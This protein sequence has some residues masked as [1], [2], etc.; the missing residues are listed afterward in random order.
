MEGLVQ[1]GGIERPARD[2]VEY[3]LPGP[4]GDGLIDLP[5]RIVHRG[6][7][8][9]ADQF[10]DQAFEIRIQ[11]GRSY[12]S[13]DWQPASKKITGR[14]RVRNASCRRRMFPR[15]L[16]RTWPKYLA[17]RPGTSVS[18]SWANGAK[19]HPRR[20]IPLTARSS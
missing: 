3:H 20:A 6:T 13:S 14:P 16:D 12:S 7:D 18:M 19:R 15:T 10:E 9:P 4:R 1:P 11:S 5:A 2:H 8:L 17:V